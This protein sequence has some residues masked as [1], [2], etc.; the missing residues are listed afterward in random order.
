M[1]K[2]TD[3]QA[4][5]ETVETAKVTPVASSKSSL[6]ASLDETDEYLNVL[7][8]GREGSGKTTAAVSLANLGYGN[9]LVVNAEGGMK[10]NTLK[11]HGIDTSRIQVW[12]PSGTA[13]SHAG[14][15]E[16]YRQIKAD[17]ARDPK[18][19]AGVV[20]DSATE[21]VQAL[22]DFVANDRISK[23]ERKGVNIDQIDQFFT[24]RSDYGTMS[25]MFR[26]ILRK[27]RDLPCHFVVTALERRDVDDDTGKV[28][29]GPA[30]TPGVQTDLLGYVD[31][32]LACSA[33]DDSEGKPFRAL[34]RSSGKYRGKD[35]L[36][37]LPKVLVNPTIGRIL[38]YE[39]G[40]LT[41]DTDP[42]QTQLNNPTPKEQSNA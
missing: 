17:L 6:F 38:D 15:D 23:A 13:I 10:K 42:L 36:G 27:F 35:R 22:V 33:A 29:Y 26:D 34:T 19:W 11:R 40:T 21:V 7:L 9:V 25:K 41:E 32:V 37:I 2:V 14:L 8:F 1:A 4:P 30:V 39:N 12:P 24:D 16:V 3:G 20:F 18:S 5:A 31:L 28:Q